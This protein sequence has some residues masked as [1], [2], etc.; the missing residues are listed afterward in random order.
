MSPQVLRAWD[1]NWKT[2]KPAAEKHVGKTTVQVM[3]VVAA[4]AR[5]M[6]PAKYAWLP[7]SNDNINRPRGTSWD[8]TTVKSVLHNL[9]VYATLERFG[10]TYGNYLSFKP[11]RVFQMR[12]ESTER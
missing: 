6:V 1:E 8:K 7:R 12:F 9:V 3:H 10:P 5:K 4:S 2:K 11:G